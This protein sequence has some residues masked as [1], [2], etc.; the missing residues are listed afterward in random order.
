M[1][2]YKR[3]HLTNAS[4]LTFYD[5]GSYPGMTVLVNFENT[6]NSGAEGGLPIVH[7]NDEK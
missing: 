6:A 1:T 4:V 5:P 7:C 2:A 3:K